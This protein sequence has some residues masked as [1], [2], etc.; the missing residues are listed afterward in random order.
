M[1]LLIR[2]ILNLYSNDSSVWIERIGPHVHVEELCVAVAKDFE[3]FLVE[4]RWI[5]VVKDRVEERPTVE[6]VHEEAN[7]FALTVFFDISFY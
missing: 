1:I 2:S 6:F 3:H 7:Y 4:V 5:R